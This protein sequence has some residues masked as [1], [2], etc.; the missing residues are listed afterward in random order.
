[1]GA[2]FRLRG[3]GGSLPPGGAVV[4]S[5]GRLGGGRFAVANPLFSSP[6]YRYSETLKRRKLTPYRYGETL[7]RYKL[8]SYR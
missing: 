6:E 7:K 4:G 2:N 1:M 5:G 3:A 8:T